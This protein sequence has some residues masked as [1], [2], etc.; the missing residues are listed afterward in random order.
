MTVPCL[1]TVGLGG[2]V[3]PPTVF[4]PSEATAK[5][6]GL[7]H[8]WRILPH[9][10]VPDQNIAHPRSA[11]SGFFF[12]IFFLLAVRHSQVNALLQLSGA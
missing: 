2:G 5:T 4:P 10:Q 12:C 1:C 8:V 6:L 7:E 3:L 9:S 11:N